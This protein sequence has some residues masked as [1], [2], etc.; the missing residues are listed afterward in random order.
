MRIQLIDASKPAN[1]TALRWLQAVTLPGDPVVD[2]ADGHWWIAREDDVPVAYAGLQDLASWP[3][4]AYVARVGVIPKYRGLGLQR[5]LIA[6]LERKAKALGYA[7][8]VTTT[9]LN[10]ISANNF[11]RRGFVTYEPALHWGAEGTIYW[12]KELTA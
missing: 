4:S 9:Y 11:I 8:L 10:P 7:R 6:A 12:L 2:P 3:G 5:L 1:D